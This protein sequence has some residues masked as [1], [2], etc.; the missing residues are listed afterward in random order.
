MN[1][2]QVV[3]FFLGSL[4]FI[5][6]YKEK[7]KNLIF[8]I[9]LTI[10]FNIYS[11]NDSTNIDYLSYYNLYEYDKNLQKEMLLDSLRNRFNITNQFNVIFKDTSGYISRIEIQ[12]KTGKNFWYIFENNQLEDLF[13]KKLLYEFYDL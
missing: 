3:N 5:S 13:Q 10:S 2:L 4:I 7:M 1:Y 11:Q 9:T 6:Y 12:S 8:F